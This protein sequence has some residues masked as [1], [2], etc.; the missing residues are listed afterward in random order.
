MVWLLL[1]V[2]GAIHALSF[3][4]DPLPGWTLPYVQVMSLAV[5]AYIV[6]G[7]KRSR[8]AAMSV[9]VFS[10][11]SICVGVYWLYISMNHFGGMA[12]PLAALAVF[13]FALYL[14]LYAG[15]AGACTAWL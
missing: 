8:R 1:L 4:P 3:S 13:L 15:P 12:A 5:P 14:S 2:A 6:F 9:S 7:T 10:T 11:S